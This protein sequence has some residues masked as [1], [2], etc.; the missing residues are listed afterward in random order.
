MILSRNFRTQLSR[1]IREG[2]GVGGGGYLEGSCLSFPFLGMDLIRAS[3]QIVG[4]ESVDQLCFLIRSRAEMFQNF[5]CDSIRSQSLLLN[6][7]QCFFKL[8]DS[9]AFG[10]AWVKASTSCVLEHIPCLGQNISHSVS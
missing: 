7:F 5:I 3:F 9:Q 4:T 2:R 10:H 1:L 8:S 6:L